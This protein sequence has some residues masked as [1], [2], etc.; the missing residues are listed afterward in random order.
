MLMGVGLLIV[1]GPQCAGMTT[2]SDSVLAPGVIVGDGSTVVRE[3]TRVSGSNTEDL[4]TFALS[5][6]REWGPPTFVAEAIAQ[7]TRQ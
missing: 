6:W 5:A 1:Y 2:G 7:S 3:R 4:A